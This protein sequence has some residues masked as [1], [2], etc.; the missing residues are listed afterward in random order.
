MKK[1]NQRIYFWILIAFALASVCYVFQFTLADPGHRLTGL[2][3]DAIKNYFTYLYHIGYGRGVWF[4][5]MNYPYGEHITYTDAQPLLSIPFSYVH[6]QPQAAL[7]ILHVLVALSYVIACVFLYRILRYFNVAP[8]FAILFSLAILFLSPQLM[9]ASGH[10][11]L[12]YA[13]YIPMIF[14]WS[15]LYRETGRLRYIVWFTLVSVLMTF[16]HPYFA[17]TACLWAGFYGVGVLITQWKNRKVAFRHIVPVLVSIII[18]F[19][20]VQA[21]IKLT[22]PV[23]DRPVYPY[24][25]LHSFTTG[26]QI[27]TSTRSPVWQ[28]IRDITGMQIEEMDG[29]KTGYPGLVAIVVIIAVVLS[30]AIFRLRKRESK[31]YKQVSFDPVWLILAGCVLL[32]TRGVPIAW[33]GE[34]M[35]DYVAPVR[36]FRSVGRFIWMFY[37]IIA[38]YGAVVLYRWFEWKR[39]V[40]PYVAHAVMVIALCVW[41]LE[42]IAYINNYRQDTEHAA[43][44]YAFYFSKEEEGWN[45]FLADRHY[46]SADFQAMLLLPFIHVGS[47][48]IW[49]RGEHGWLIT[50]GSKAALQ[51]HLPIV[52][53]MMSRSGWG[54]TF[55]QVKIDAGPYV[56]KP[57]LQEVK[58]NRPYLLLTY[59]GAP[60]SYDESYLVQASDAIGV[61]GQTT[62]YAFYPERI[63]QIDREHRQKAISIVN[64]LDRQTDTVVNGR[65][66]DVYIRHFSERLGKDHS[67]FGAGSF[68]VVDKEHAILDSCSLIPDTSRLYEFSA[69]VLVAAKDYKSPYF[70]VEM[71]DEHNQTIGV[72]SIL[73]KESVDN[74][75]LWLRAGAYFTIPAACR[76]IKIH[77]YNYNRPSYLALDEMMLRPATM[78]VFSK[79]ESGRVLVNNHVL[80]P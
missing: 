54:E 17:A 73:G 29:E 30:A 78:T 74:E 13:C 4:D 7:A 2:G 32:F 6:L 25:I 40:R 24:D 55:K 14:Y 75:G 69:W 47:E 49:L 27:V 22:D 67:F 16:L 50:L 26:E 46:Q 70:D 41:G 5:G 34:R 15:L 77:L 19:A 61:F 64:A 23:K 8:V 68:G 51:L 1:N 35:L 66:K 18:I 31:F 11:G 58:D 53:V 39:T 43:T 60:L 33:G 44:N 28:G 57:L 20:V 12:S 80:N 79:D 48:K 56:A 52:D 36:Q 38:V 21:F 63:R 9:R 71:L 59:D 37:Y 62:V 10:F 65:M 42:S 45:K 72:Q 3:G 76:K